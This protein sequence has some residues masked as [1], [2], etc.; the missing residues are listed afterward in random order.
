MDLRGFFLLAIKRKKVEDGSSDKKRSAEEGAS[1]RL[2][3]AK[4]KFP[5]SRKSDFPRVIHRDG[6]MFCTW[7]LFPRHHR[8]AGK[9]KNIGLVTYRKVQKLSYT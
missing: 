2:P 4:R 7:Y 6:A 8:L 9:E 3:P 1:A 5:Q